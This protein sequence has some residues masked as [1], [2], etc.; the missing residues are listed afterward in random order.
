MYSEEIKRLIEQRNYLI[1]IKEYI[2]IIKSPQVDHVI[3]K[4][5]EFNIWTTDGYKFKL[6]IRKER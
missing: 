2:E 1:S 4:N 3:Y 5:Q 6:Q